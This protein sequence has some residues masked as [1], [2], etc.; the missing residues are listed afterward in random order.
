[1]T[2]PK[3]MPDWLAQE[4]ADQRLLA[5]NPDCP[6]GL[7]LQREIRERDVMDTS[8][9]KNGPYAHEY[10]AARR[11]LSEIVR[12]IKSVTKPTARQSRSASASRARHT[13]SHGSSSKSGDDGSGSGDP[14]PEP[15]PES[16]SELDPSDH[17]PD[18]RSHSSTDAH[19][20]AAWDPDD[21]RPQYHPATEWHGINNPVVYHGVTQDSWND[22]AQCARGRVRAV[23]RRL[24][25]GFLLKEVAD[26]L[27]IS[28]HTAGE[29]AR[30]IFEEVIAGL[31][32][33]QANLFDEPD[34]VPRRSTRGRKKKP[35]KKKEVAE[36]E[37]QD[38]FVA[39][40]E[41]GGGA[42]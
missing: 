22:I 31:V 40:D 25:E 37:Q 10:H 29:D 30:G 34:Y 39:D 35:G 9:C 26:L 15:D 41:K 32:T 42:S 21:P 23:C 3:Q 12:R 2:T 18:R 7:Q 6:R 11:A 28:A 27:L 14:D 36:Q 24:G 5:T 8:G 16:E 1:M 19:S 20:Y 13:Q 33:K 4:I 38:L 17:A